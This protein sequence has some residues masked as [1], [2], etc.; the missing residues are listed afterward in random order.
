[1]RC[2]REARQTAITRE[3]D[4]SSIRAVAPATSNQ[5]D[6]TAL[7]VKSW[8]PGSYARFDEDLPCGNLNFTSSA[9]SQ[10]GPFKDKGFMLGVLFI[11]TELSDFPI[12]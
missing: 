9:G 7:R 10:A 12:F 8:L 3:L 1:M 6:T 2:V 11:A 5:A 4:T